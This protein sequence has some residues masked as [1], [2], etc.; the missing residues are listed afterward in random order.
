M[1]ELES[2]PDILGLYE[3]GFSEM[4]ERYFSEKMW[5]EAAVVERIIGPGSNQVE[6]AN[7]NIF[8]LCAF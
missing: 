5:P 7:G 4:S 3:Q 6:E 2:V 1:L 8:N